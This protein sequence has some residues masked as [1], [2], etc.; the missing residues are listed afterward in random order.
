MTPRTPEAELTSG[1][2]G[3]VTATPDRLT[4]QGLR[5]LLIGGSATAIQLGLFALLEGWTGNQLANVIAWSITTVLSTVAHRGF[6]FRKRDRDRYDQVVGG[7]TSLASLGL[8]SL[9]LDLLDPQGGFWGVMVVLGVNVI[10]GC[11]RFALLRGWF[12]GKRRGR[13]P[14]VA[15]APAVAADVPLS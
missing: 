10:V 4:I 1:Y 2:S 8:T 15:D 6:T 14:L 12:L 5:Y 7:L 11:T 9:A 3:R 13:T